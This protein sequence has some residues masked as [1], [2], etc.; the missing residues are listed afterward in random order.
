[1]DYVAA[2]VMVWIMVSCLASPLLG[3]VIHYG[4]DEQ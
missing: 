4:S 3:R 2:A 1:M